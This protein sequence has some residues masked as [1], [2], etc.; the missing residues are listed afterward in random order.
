MF[1]SMPTGQCITNADLQASN[2]PGSVVGNGVRMGVEVPDGLAPDIIAAV[3]AFVASPVTTQR[4]K[5][6]DEWANCN[7][8]LAALPPVEDPDPYATIRARLTALRDQC[9]TDADA[10]GGLI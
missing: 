1:I 8:K 9:L 6:S 2:L 7:A 3:A 10:L 4:R 5:V